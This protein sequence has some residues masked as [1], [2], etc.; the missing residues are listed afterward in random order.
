MT[1]PISAIGAFGAA[2]FPLFAPAPIKHNVRQRILTDN[3]AAW[4]KI[5]GT[6]GTSSTET[7]NP[8]PGATAHSRFLTTN[9]GNRWAITLATPMDLTGAYFRYQIKTAVRTQLASIIWL[10]AT[11]QAQYTAGNYMVFKVAPSSTGTTGNANWIPQLDAWVRDGVPWELMSTTGTGANRA[12]IGYIA[13]HIQSGSSGQT[14]QT[15]IASIESVVKSSAK[16][17][18]CIWHD[19]SVLGGF[20]G[21]KGKLDAYGWPGNEAAIWAAIAGGHGSNSM[22][23]TDLAAAK[24]AGWQIASHA[25]SNP[26]HVDVANPAAFLSYAYRARNSARKFG[27]GTD[28]DARDFTWWGGLSLTEANISA[29]RSVHRAGRWNTSGLAYPEQL[30]PAEPMVTKALLMDTGNTFTGTYK[31]LIDNAIACKGLAQ[32]VF[33]QDIGGN[34]T[35]TAEFD[36]M[37]AYLDTK[38]ADIDVT[39][40]AQALASST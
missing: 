33:H 19:D 8:A 21:M 40:F 11:S 18:I 27:Y 23:G 24:A 25:P 31:P 35:S 26:E 4:T 30:P 3:A 36:S 7:T 1:R 32:I 6:G 9:T 16:A 22:D 14:A 29:L 12:S 17:K 38:R 5:Q 28:V 15:D 20:T 2:G 37:L 10:F 13:L 39:T 34:P